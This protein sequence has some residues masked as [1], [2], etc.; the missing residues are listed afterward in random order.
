MENWAWGGTGRK[1]RNV[2]LLRSNEWA[3][4]N[5]VWVTEPVRPPTSAPEVLA[6]GTRLGQFAPSTG[7]NSGSLPPVAAYTSRACSAL[8]PMAFA[9]WWQVKQV[10]PFVPRGWK[11]A[12]EAVV[13][14]PA[15]W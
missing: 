4:S 7:A 1:M 9:V 8:I 2:P 11:K 5:L 3:A 10:R 14:A 15:G 13:V 12:L 6:A